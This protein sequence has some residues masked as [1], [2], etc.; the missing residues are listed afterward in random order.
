M[1]GEYRKK[2]LSRI[3]FP[4]INNLKLRASYGKSGRPVGEEFAYLSKYLVNNA[5]VW[6]VDGIQE[7]GVYE[8]S[9]PNIAL[10]WETVWKANLGLDLN[11]WD[12]L[13]GMSFDVYRD[14][15]SDKILAPD[16]IVPIEYGIGLSDEN[17]GKEERYGF[18]L[19]LNNYTKLSN[20]FSIQ[21]NF[22]FGFTRNKQLE[23]REAPG[24]YN[25]PRFRQTGNPSNQI[26][27]YRSAG[28][29]VD[30]DDID[31]W[32]Y[33]GS[34]LPGDVKYVDINGDG[35]INSEDEVVIGKGRVPE[36]MYGYNLTLKY[37]R[38]DA[39]FILTGNR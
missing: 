32:A 18:D 4:A 24:T 14:Y 10:T 21:N 25:I 38:L 35:K 8:G 20:D 12:G 6:G 30:Q 9:E 36:I 31:N 17:A 27:G 2:D 11:M 33:Q 13:F 37:K 16:A 5:Y 29:F 23:I 19:T 3:I 28:L 39:K 15:R 26:R 7:Q 1:V 22:V 34:V